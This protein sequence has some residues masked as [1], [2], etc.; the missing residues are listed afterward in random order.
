M[1]NEDHVAVLER[2]DIRRALRA[3]SAP[4]REA[5]LLHYWA[6]MSQPQIA[7]LLATPL[8]T[9]KL[10]VFRGRAKLR[11]ATVGATDAPGAVGVSGSR[12]TRR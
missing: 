7:K 11:D 4:E 12:R 9:I 2:L 6:D 10:R 8:G 3:L 1:E 5:V